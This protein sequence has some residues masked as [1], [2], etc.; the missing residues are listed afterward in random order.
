MTMSSE[1]ANSSSHAPRPLHNAVLVTL[2]SLI[3]AGGVIGGFLIGRNVT[4]DAFIDRVSALG[5]VESATLVSAGSA[6][7]SLL[8]IVGSGL[9]DPLTAR[10]LSKAYEVPGDD[11]ER[12]VKRLR[13]VV[14]VPPYRP[15]PFVGHIARPFFG[16]DLQINVLGFRDERQTYIN[17]PS[18]TVRM[19]ITGASTAWGSGASSQKNTISYVLEQ[20]LNERVSRTTGYRYEVVNTAFPGWSTTQ[21]KLLIQ[22]RLVDMHPD[23]VLMLSGNNDVHWSLH[24]RDIRWHYNY[25]DENY[26]TLLNEV[27]KHS[28]HPEW[29]VAVPFSSRPVECPDLGRTTARNVEEAAFFAERVNARLF[30]ALQPNIVSTAKH[31]T[32]YE[33]R[34]LQAQDKPYWDTCYQALRD[35]LARVSA[36]NYRLLDLSRSFG[37]L[38]DSTELFVDAYHFVDV[39][40]RLIAQALADQIDWGS[41]VPSSAVTAEMKPLAIVSFGQ[42]ELAEGKSFSE[43]LDGAF[44]IRIIPNRINKNLLVVFDR[45]VLPA[46]ISD[47]SITASIPASLHANKG[48]HTIR[49]V[50]G[51]SGETSA[52]VE[53]HGR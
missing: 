26:V 30:F 7:R 12:L 35:E 8:Q 53:F 39:G 49:I 28:G 11:R 1:S 46:V 40:N 10:A 52:A 9:D 20:I 4:R 17:K 3:V 42:V 25:Q 15:A 19:F 13:D 41:I 31:L 18:R 5:A 24:G 14:W 45:S 50:D 16:D 51:V 22:Q 33:R 2:I 37:A 44:A 27:Y 34:I 23:V 32:E 36:R 38:D 29:T 6:P 48:E 47:D 43:R 21:E